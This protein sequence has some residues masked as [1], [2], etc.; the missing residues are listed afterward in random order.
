MNL[1]TLVKLQDTEISF[2]LRQMTRKIQKDS[3]YKPYE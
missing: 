3:K 1:D 2:T